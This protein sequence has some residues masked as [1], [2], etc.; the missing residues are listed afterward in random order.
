[1]RLVPGSCRAV[2]WRADSLPQEVHASPLFVHDSNRRR[3]CTQP[4]SGHVQPRLCKRG[5]RRAARNGDWV[6]GL[7][8][9]YAPSGDLSGHLVYAMCIEE[10]LTLLEYDHQAPTRWPHRIPNVRSAD[11]SDRLGDCIYAFEGSSIRQRQGVH[12][13]SNVETDLSGEKCPHIERFLL[14]WRPRDQAPRLSAAY[15]PPNA[16]ASE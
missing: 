14:L 1:M 7:G 3:C 9:K 16:G 5:I 15:M 4:F 8:S 2:G 10:V 13:P 11:L 12:G 6:A